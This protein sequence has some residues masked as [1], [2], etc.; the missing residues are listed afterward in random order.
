M[1][2]V[3]DEDDRVAL[4]G[5]L[6]RLAVD[7]GHER[8][9]RV[10]R[11]QAAQLGLGVDRGRDAVGGEHGHGALGDLVAELVDE[12]RSAL[13]E[14][15]DDVLVVDDL[16]AHVDGRAVQLE[17]ALDRLDRAVDAG[18]VAARSGE[19]ELVGSGGH[20]RLSVRTSCEHR[21][22]GQVE[23]ALADRRRGRRSA[24]A[25]TRTATGSG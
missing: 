19:Q 24:G 22:A 23:R 12:H 4:G 3:A 16:L 14:L 1:A 13:R 2:G 15:L 10:D 21:F 7:L 11:A 25:S 6:D 8:A 9:R 20:Y 5:E 18:A 17:R